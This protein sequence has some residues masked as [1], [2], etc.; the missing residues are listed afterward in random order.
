MSGSKRTV[1][2]LPPCFPPGGTDP[3]AFT[4]ADTNFPR[5]PGVRTKPPVYRADQPPR[6]AAARISLQRSKSLALGLQ[7]SRIK[8]PPG[9]SARTARPPAPIT[10]RAAAS[11]TAG[12]VVTASSGLFR[13][14]RFGLMTIV[15]PGLTNVSHPPRSP[16][17]RFTAPCTASGS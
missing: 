8:R 4:A 3:G 13:I 17:S 16:T 15:S 6:Q 7:N 1:P 2:L 9:L 10:E 5:K 12:W 14:N 11:M